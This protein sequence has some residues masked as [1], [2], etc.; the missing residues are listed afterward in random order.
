MVL[1]TQ[2]V[3]LFNLS[4]L[5]SDFP[6]GWKRATIILLVKGGNTNAMSNY[7][8]VSLLPQPGQLIEKVVHRGLSNYLENNNLLSNNQGR[9]RKNYS[10]IKS[11]VDLNDIIFDDM[12]NGLITAS[13]FID[14]RKAFD[15][16]I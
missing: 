6:S 10:T 3:H 12:N 4:L 9:F 14:L 11:I 5:K 7:R 15:T 1:V 13:V 8:P 16:Q 2:L